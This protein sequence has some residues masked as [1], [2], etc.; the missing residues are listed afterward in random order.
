MKLL[1]VV[2]AR[3]QFIK[4]AAVSRAVAEHN[5]DLDPGQQLQGLIIHTGQHYDYE[6][7]K[8][9]FEELHLPKPD[10][11][12]EVGSGSHGKQTGEMLEQTE[13]VLLEEQ[14]DIVL[15]Y[16]DTN[17][18]LAG[19]VAAAKL[20]IPVGHVEAGLRSFN[21]MM[22]EEINRVLSDHVSDLLFC[23]TEAAVENLKREGFTNIVNDGRLVEFANNSPSSTLNSRL[24]ALDAPLVLNVGD[25]MY[26]S[27]LQNLE[28][29]EKTSTVLREL[30]LVGEEY[31]LATVH[32]AENTDEPGRLRGILT[33]LE[34]LAE[35]GTPVVC[36]LHP[37]TRNA[38][39]SLDT[40]ARP[41]GVQFIEPVSY[42]DMLL[43]EKHA[44]LILTDS[45]GVQKEAYFVQVPC[46]TLRDETEWGELVDAG[47]NYLAGADSKRIVE[48]AQRA[49]T[50]RE[51]QSGLQLYGDGH[52]AERILRVLEMSG[53]RGR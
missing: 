30:R 10:Y 46:V 16:G 7:S 42:R 36:P 25:V 32:R 40:S 28:V 15:V 9:F 19:A 21:R 4:M 24:L 39:S 6:L 38:L 43:L 37:R 13:A 12:L 1:H 2:G 29:A 50:S 41:R 48:A 17:S 33:A 18:T 31:Y 49:L 22:P 20:H 27:V 14:P 47:W 8:L 51:Q 53:I 23:P 44:K 11:N 35:K 45:G 34:L 52:A 5:Q 26:D 3:P